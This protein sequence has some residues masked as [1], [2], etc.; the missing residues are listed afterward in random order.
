MTYDFNAW[1]QIEVCHNLMKQAGDHPKDVQEYTAKMAPV[2]ACIM[3]K[4]NARAMSKGACFGQQYLL[5]KGLEI[6]G[7]RG[8]KSNEKELR[9]FRTGSI[10]GNEVSSERSG[11]VQKTV[12]PCTKRARARNARQ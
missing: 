5:K 7:E 8:V 3:S 2:V 6:F 11:E 12:A 4:M 10:Y 9:Q 1:Y